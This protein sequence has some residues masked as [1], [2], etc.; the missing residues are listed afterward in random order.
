M[1]WKKPSSAIAEH[2]E[3]AVS[4]FHPE[5]RKM[6]GHPVHF[7]NGNMFAGV[8]GDDI[9]IRLREDD[10]RRLLAEND[11][12]SMFEPIAGR[13]MREYVVLPES[14]HG[15]SQELNQ[16]L[17]RSFRFVRSLPPKEKKVGKDRRGR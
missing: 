2:L 11:E 17:E 9:F 10:K 4:R 16:W 13:P 6:F 8:F 7:I 14:I 12:V 5:K 3:S 1:A 15:D